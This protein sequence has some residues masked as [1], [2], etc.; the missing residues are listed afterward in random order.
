MENGTAAALGPLSMMEKLSPAVFLYDPGVNQISNIDTKAPRMVVIFSWMGARDMHIIK[1][2]DQHRQL[3]P[4]SKILLVKHPYEHNF[5]SW[6]AQAEIAAAVPVLRAVSELCPLSPQRSDPQVLFHVFSNG[7][8]I[9]STRFHKLY[10]EANADHALNIPAHVTIFDSCPGQFNYARTYL[11]LSQGVSIIVKPLITFFLLGYWIC[12]GIFGGPSP[13]ATMALA[14]ISDDLL[15]LEARR[16]YI[17]SEADAMI[18]WKDVEQHA[19]DAERAGFKVLTEK[20]TG[21]PHV[22]HARGDPERYW[23]LVT[24]IWSGGFE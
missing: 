21:S 14:L 13:L 1:Y 2:F 23:K 16:L 3:F 19:I 10:R 4:T 6:R 17:Y 7:G 12:E 5:N 15:S 9:N 24:Q 11:A 18:D 20:F 22:A 8:C